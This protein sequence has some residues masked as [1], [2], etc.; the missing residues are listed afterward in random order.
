MDDATQDKLQEL[1]DLELAI[2]VSLISGQHAIL[3]GPSNMTRDLGEEVRLLCNAT[4]GLR[5]ATID[6]SSKTT[7]DEFSQ[8]VLIDVNDSFEDAVEQSGDNT[9]G[10]LPAR[11]SSGSSPVYR[12]SI[13][14]NHLD[15]RRVADVVV[16]TNLD[17][18]A[19]DVQVQVLELLRTKR[20]FTHT[21]MHSAP[22]D[23]L[24]VAIL[25][26]PGARLSIHLNDMFAL[27]HFHTAEDGLPYLNGTA[28]PTAAP[29]F[30]SQDVRALRDLSTEVRLT[31]EVA[32]Y[33]HNLVVFMRMSRYVK[34][35][36][37]ATATRQL[38]ALALALA[39]LHGL[40]YVPPSLVA[41]A[42]KK[43]YPNR[44]VLAT[45]ANER[46]LQWGSD[47][48]AIRLLLEGVTVEDVIEDV[49]RS[50]APPL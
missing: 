37:T 17:L 19:K 24:F 15:E 42:A 6:C 34:G 18:A 45:E 26:K 41:L 47:V 40:D 36:V 31:G 32:A 46:S 10:A 1:G 33:L 22:R 8:A 11:V 23:L 7:V 14:N 30:S 35:G 38:R 39:P 25:S 9:R 28:E 49:I 13:G 16:T 29:T 4:F 3:F 27:S 43:V 48:E 12:S 50:V 21:A 44:L 2:L 5:V 20:I